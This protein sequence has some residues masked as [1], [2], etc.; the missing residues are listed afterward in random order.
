MKESLC[1]FPAELLPG[2][3]AVVVQRFPSPCVQARRTEG[4]IQQIDVLWITAGLGCDGETI[5]M[6][7]AMQPS[8]EDV[9]LGGIPWIPKVNFHNPFLAQANGDEFLKPFHKAAAGKLGP[10]I[11]VIEG[12]IPDESNKQEGYWASLGTDKATGQP[13]TTCAWI[14]RLAPDAWAV[15]AV[16]TCATYGGIHAM[17]G[18]PTGAMGVPDYLGWQ[19][20]CRP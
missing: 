18:N 1:I 3:M 8:I 7:A 2:L 13:I 11:L 16:G 20:R 10:F 15:V 9:V 12:S 6:T 5:A 14:D 19:W 17:E 4:C